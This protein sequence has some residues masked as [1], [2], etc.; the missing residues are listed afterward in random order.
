MVVGL[1]DLHVDALALSPLP[2]GQLQ[3]GQLPINLLELSWG[4]QQ[5]RLVSQPKYP[6]W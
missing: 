2:G 3:P 5:G 4:Q 6:L 1:A